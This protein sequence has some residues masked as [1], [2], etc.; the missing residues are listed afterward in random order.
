MKKVAI[1]LSG[2][3][4]KLGDRFL[5]PT[6]LYSSNPYIDFSICFKSIKKH[7]VNANSDYTFDFFIHSWNEDLQYDLQSLYLPKKALFED[8]NS[9]KEE[10]LRKTKTE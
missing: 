3:M 1:C 9:Y 5:T 6:A 10:I 4:S 8:Q 2:A 7:I